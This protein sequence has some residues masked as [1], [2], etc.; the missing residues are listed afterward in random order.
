MSYQFKEVAKP[1]VWK[2][3]Y[4]GN[5]IDEAEKCSSK[6]NQL[7][8]SGWK[9]WSTNTM[10]VGKVGYIIYVLRKF[11]KETEDVSTNKDSQESLE[12]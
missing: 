3:N 6:I 11:K 1:L 2:S 12:Q 9:L 8:D 4:K 10:T 7:L 5:I